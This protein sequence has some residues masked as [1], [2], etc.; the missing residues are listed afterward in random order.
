M[1]SI[2][3]FPRSYRAQKSR[4]QNVG[5]AQILFFTGVRYE[6]HLDAPRPSAL[7]KTPSIRRRRITK[8]PDKQQA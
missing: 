8:S 7:K 1:V 6:R 2:V 3:S 5:S 4:P